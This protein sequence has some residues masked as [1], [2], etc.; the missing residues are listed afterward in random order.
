MAILPIY[1][2]DAKVL[3]SKTHDI[4][5]SGVELTKLILEMFETM[6]QANGIGLAANQVGVELSMFVVDLSVTNE[7][8]D[9]PPRVFINPVITDVWGDNIMFEEGCLSVPNLREEIERPEFLHIKYRDANFEESDLEA[10]G[11]LARVIQHEFD[12]LEGI[13]FTDYLRGLK[14]RLVLPALNKIKKGEVETDY[15]L[16]SIEQMDLV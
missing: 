1:T 13:F 3:R 15:H 7:Y 14:K 12:H 9:E 4:K 11:L 8:K 6:K 10:D 2:Y 5:K 16:V